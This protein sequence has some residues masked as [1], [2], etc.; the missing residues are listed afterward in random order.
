MTP[1]SSIGCRSYYLFDEKSNGVQDT[2]ARY[3]SRAYPVIR[4]SNATGEG[5][6]CGYEQTV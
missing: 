1:Y 3:L 4:R 2:V 5:L 6:P